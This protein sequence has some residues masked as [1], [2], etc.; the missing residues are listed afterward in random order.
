MQHTWL[1]QDLVQKVFGLE[2]HLGN[3]KPM[4]RKARWIATHFLLRLF[5]LQRAIFKLHDRGRGALGPSHWLSLA[6][7]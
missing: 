7:V 1:F 2:Y 6:L 3:V 4:C 5:N